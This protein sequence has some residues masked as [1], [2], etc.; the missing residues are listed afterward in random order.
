MKTSVIVFTSILCALLHGEDI[1][2][3]S[4]RFQTVYI[5][6]MGNGFDQ[7]LASRLTNA[8]VLWV[9]LDPKNADAVMT[10]SLD[11]A[12]WAWLHRTYGPPAAGSPTTP[13][14]NPSSGSSPDAGAAATIPASGSSAAD[15]ARSSM[16]RR[17]APYSSSGRRGTVFLVDP[18]RRLVLW[19]AC[20]LPKNSSDAESDRIASHIT[21]QLKVAFGKK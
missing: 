2:R 4:P 13:A 3:L 18:R 9:V 5:T 12:F 21:N 15:D 16:P 17:V 7:H 6:E 1:V 19:S 11:D 10:E 8:H 20:E 14:T